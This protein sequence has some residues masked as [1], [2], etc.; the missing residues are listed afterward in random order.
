MLVTVACIK[1]NTRTHTQSSFSRLTVLHKLQGTVSFWTSNGNFLALEDQPLVLVYEVLGLMFAVFVTAWLALYI[2]RWFVFL[3]RTRTHTHLFLS[4]VNAVCSSTCLPLFSVWKWLNSFVITSLTWSRRTQA[5]PTR[6]WGI[7]SS[8]TSF[9]HVMHVTHPHTYSQN[10]CQSLLG[11]L[12]NHPS[13]V[14]HVDWTRL[15]CSPSSIGTSWEATHGWPVCSLLCLFD[16]LCAVYQSWAMHSIHVCPNYSIIPLVSFQFF[17]RA[18]EL[19]MRFIVLLAI[20]VT[21]STTAE[22][23][24]S[25]IT[26]E[27]AAHFN[28]RRRVL[29]YQFLYCSKWLCHPNRNSCRYLLLL[30][31]VMN[32]VYPVI[33]VFVELY[34][35]GWLQAWVR[36]LSFVFSSCPH[37]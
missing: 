7:S 29:L 37:V 9:F 33:E 14:Y 32:L 12:S 5:T 35:L 25:W 11:L 6:V 20:I 13:N 31:V 4:G 19:V 16:A 24:R 28:L 22:R 21:L 3:S 36:I 10:C 30:F 2:T 17:I 15:A 8:S 18:T 27:M 34:V 23:L 26:F 1:G